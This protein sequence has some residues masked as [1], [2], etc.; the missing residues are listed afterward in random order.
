MNACGQ[1]SLANIGFHGSSIR[2]NGLIAPALQ[3]LLGGGPLKNGE[4]RV[5]DKV[6]KVP[7]KR[8]GITLTTILDNYSENK[9]EGELFNDYYD[10]RGKIYFYDLLKTIASAETLTPNE[11][12]DWGHTTTFK[13]EIGVGECAGVTIDLVS[14]LLLEGEEKLSNAKTALKNVAFADSIYLSYS[15]FINGAKALLVGINVKT[16]SQ[17]TIINLFDEHFVDT[18]QIGLT[19]S[20]TE[21]VLG[22]KNNQPTKDFA[23]KYYEE[24]KSF[25]LAI[26]LLRQKQLSHASNS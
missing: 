23:Q 15:T 5:S 11:Y 18:K 21:L 1:H 7:S 25:S 10:R 4:G 20:F 24:A 26:Q 17:K 9:V 8:G 12:L 2:T 13:T 14:T 22:I 16:N 3:V 6:I 19:G